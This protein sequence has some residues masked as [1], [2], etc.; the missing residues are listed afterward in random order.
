MQKWIKGLLF[1]MILWLPLAGC[2]SKEANVAIEAFSIEEM[3]D[4]PDDD[5][6]YTQKG[7]KRVNSITDTKKSNNILTIKVSVLEDYYDADGHYLK[8]VIASSEQRK[9]LFTQEVTSSEN[10]KE[11]QEPVTILVPDTGLEGAFNKKASLTEDESEQL[12]AHILD[13]IRLL[14]E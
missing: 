1:M 6:L 14:N 7:Y 2:A 10:K 11:K 5:G 8:S 13:S 12:K 3:S 9:N 4:T